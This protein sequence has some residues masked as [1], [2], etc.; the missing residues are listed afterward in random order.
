MNSESNSCGQA[1]IFQKVRAQLAVSTTF[2]WKA[3]PVLVFVA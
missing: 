3:T 2:V 1:R